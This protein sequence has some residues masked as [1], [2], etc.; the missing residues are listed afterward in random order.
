MANFDSGVARYIKAYAVVTVAFPVD[1]RGNADISCNQ[2][3]YYSRS[4]KMCQ[5]NKSTVNYPDKFVGRECPLILE[6]SEDE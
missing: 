6:E 3:P 4:S 2:C 5:L 1:S